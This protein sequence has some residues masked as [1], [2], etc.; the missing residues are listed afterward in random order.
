MP[1]AMVHVFV[2]GLGKRGVFGGRYE[3]VLGRHVWK[4]GS[5]AP[6][7]FAAADGLRTLVQAK[8]NGEGDNVER[9]RDPFSWNEKG[10]LDC[11]ASARG[12]RKGGEISVL[13]RKEGDAGGGGDARIGEFDG[14]HV[15]ASSWRQPQ[16]VEWHVQGRGTLSLRNSHKCKL[17]HVRH[18]AGLVP[19]R[20]KLLDGVQRVKG[21]DV[22]IK[23][24]CTAVCEPHGTRDRRRILPQSF[25][26]NRMKDFINVLEYGHVL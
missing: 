10:V 17:G 1:F 11:G 18:S 20:D 22:Q 5:E 16:V 15:A 8:E 13:C 21:I 23:R 3:R 7:P 24:L 2:D 4:V 26:P 12:S 19:M 6:I 9:G 14:L 25:Q